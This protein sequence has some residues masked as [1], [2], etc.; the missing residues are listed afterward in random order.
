[1]K[2][3]WVTRARLERQKEISTFWLT[4]WQSEVKWSRKLEETIR[5]TKKAQAANAEAIVLNPGTIGQRVAGEGVVQA[6]R[7][8]PPAV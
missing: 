1:M 3:P 7:P 4:E 8:L 2:W 5:Q 6:V